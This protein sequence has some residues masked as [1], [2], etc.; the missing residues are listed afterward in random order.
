MGYPQRVQ[1]TKH[2]RVIGRREQRLQMA[3][4]NQRDLV[5]G[6]TH[7]PALASAG[8]ERGRNKME[9]AQENPPFI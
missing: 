3:K 7:I 4:K 8:E 6:G 5:G 2:S 9:G 1:V